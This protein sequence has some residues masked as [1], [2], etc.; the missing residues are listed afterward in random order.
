VSAGWILVNTPRF[1]LALSDPRDARVGRDRAYERFGVILGN[2]LDIAALAML[3][4]L[5]LNRF[6]A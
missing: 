3:I 1:P 4:G 2:N 5:E 6:P